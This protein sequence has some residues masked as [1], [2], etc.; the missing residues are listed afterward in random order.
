MVQALSFGACECDNQHV[1]SSPS[2]S[3]ITGLFSARTGYIFS[4]LSFGQVK[5][6]AIVIGLHA[7]VCCPNKKRTSNF[8]EDLSCC[9][10]N[11]F[12]HV[13][14]WQKHTITHLK[15]VHLTT[16][17]CYRIQIMN[18]YECNGT[19]IFMRWKMKCSI[20]RGEAE[21]NGTFHL[22]PNENICSIARMRKH[23]LFVLYNLYKDSNS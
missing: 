23:S 20:Q 7:N 22:S 5:L 14:H 13:T 11:T 12:V 4:N 9:L 2:S 6:M 21:L 17:P 8:Y 1:K 16:W 3:P 15:M 18:V 10:V 19:N